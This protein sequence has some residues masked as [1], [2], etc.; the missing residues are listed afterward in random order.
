MIQIQSNDWYTAWLEA[1]IQFGLNPFKVV[2][3]K[4]GNRAFSFNNVIELK[5]NDLEGLSYQ[6]VGYLGGKQRMIWRHYFDEKRFEEV[7]EKLKERVLIKGM[8]L[9]ILN[10]W[11]LQQNNQHNLDAC[12]SNMYVMAKRN[13]DKSYIIEYE[14]HIRTAEVTKRLCADFVFFHLLINKFNE[15]FEEIEINT[16]IFVKAKALYAQ[17]PFYLIARE[18]LNMPLNDQHWFTSSLDRDE[19]N[20]FKE[21]YKFKMGKRVRNY[22]I[23]LR[24]N[25]NVEGS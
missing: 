25:Q 19:K 18:I 5:T 13:K 10:Y 22:I 21:D 16:K 9:T 8:D 7:T 24:E 6:T 17:P 11:F 2:D 20:L 12:V 15:L 1:Q 4:I 3:D 14:I 23:K